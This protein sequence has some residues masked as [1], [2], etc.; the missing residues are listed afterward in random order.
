LDTDQPCAIIIIGASGDLTKRKLVPALFSLFCNDLL[1]QDFVV[2]GFARSEM[3][4]DAFR[5]HV[6]GYLTCRYEPEKERCDEK[7]A[8]FLARCRYVSGNYD[9]AA[10]FAALQ[11]AVDRHAG[12]GANRLF[13]MAIPP[14]IFVDTA[15]SIGASH[16]ADDCDQ[17]LRVVLEKPFGRDSR[18]SA[19]LMSAM[20]EL[21]REEQTY[22]IDHYLGKEVIQN[23]MILRFANGIFEPIW[24]R[25]HIE[26]VTI[27]WSERIG[28]EGRAGYFDQFAHLG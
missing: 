24:N 28:C 11:A 12:A 16:I 8:A 25:Q 22:R 1:P 6:S 14:S 21:F 18:T 23:L 2:F 5:E 13:Y 17:W 20:A 26:R 9:D 19:E 7:M 27:S 15:H 3:S 10:A 4:N